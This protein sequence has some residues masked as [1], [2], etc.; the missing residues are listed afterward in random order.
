MQNSRD[1]AGNLPL[2]PQ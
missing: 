1:G 2:Q